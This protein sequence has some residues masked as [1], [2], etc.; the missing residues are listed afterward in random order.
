MALRFGHL[1]KG[2]FLFIIG[3]F[4]IM[5]LLYINSIAVFRQG[6]MIPF[7]YSL[8]MIVSMFLQFMGFVWVALHVRSTR[9]NVVM[10]ET[11]PEEVKVFRVTRDGIIL[12][13]FAPKGLY[14]TIETI[15]YGEDADFNDMG[16]FPLRTLDGSPAVLVFDM[17]NTA[18]DV[19][20]SVG[21]KYMKKHVNDGVEGYNLWKKKKQ[22]TLKA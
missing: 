1:E 12:N 14:G 17:I 2:G 16:E 21:R 13:Q 11:L 19:R 22:K 10:D 7:W 5:L 18:I 8:L 9:A 6:E 4:P 3:M 20:R 15:V